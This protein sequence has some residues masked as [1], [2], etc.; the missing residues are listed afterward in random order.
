M[1]GIRFAS[2]VVV[3]GFCLV[4][5][6]CGPD[7]DPL[8]PPKTSIDTTTHTRS[9]FRPAMRSA[10]STAWRTESSACSMSATYPLVTPRLSRCP[11]PKTRSSPL[12]VYPAI[13]ADTLE[14]PMSIAE[15]SFSTRAAFMFAPAYIRPHAAAF[16]FCRFRFR[17]FAEIGT[18]RI[19]QIKMNDISTKQSMNSVHSRKIQ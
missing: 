2:V 8:D 13:S 12:S 4:L 17:Y 3:C 7:D 5:A 11:V 19:A 18:L 10:C 15:I 6:G 14:E 1:F 9:M 16:G